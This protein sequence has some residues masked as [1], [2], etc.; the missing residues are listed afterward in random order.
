LGFGKVDIVLA[1]PDAWEDV[2]SVDA[3]F[4]RFRGGKLR[5]WPEYLNLTDEF[6]YK[7]E[8]TEPTVVSRYSG[9]HRE[10]HAGIDIFHSFGRTESKPPD[11]GD[12]IIDKIGRASR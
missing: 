8:G 6:V 3:L 5:I 11:D 2:N 9:S 1:V 7:Y 10:R 4:K 12:A